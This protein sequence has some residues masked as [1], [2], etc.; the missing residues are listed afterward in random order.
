MQNFGDKAGEGRP[1][2][3]HRRWS[4]A[5]GG[6]NR[7]DSAGHGEKGRFPVFFPGGWRASYI[8]PAGKRRRDTDNYRYCVVDLP[9]EI[10]VL[11]IDGDAAA[12][13]AGILD[14]G[15]AW[16][17]GAA[18]VGTGL[19]PQIESPQ[20]PQQKAE[21]C[22][23]PN[24]HIANFDR[25]D[26][27]AIGALERYVRNGGGVAFFLGPLSDASLSMTPLSRRPGIVPR[28]VGRAK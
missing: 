11:L 7:R 12:K 9:A 27:S 6:D 19:R 14:A 20:Y 23:F 18:G 28:A 25:L 16:R 13:D 8:A 24:H 3:G 1:R 2:A 21:A 10:P 22:R 17:S 26:K 15:F 5:S 4:R